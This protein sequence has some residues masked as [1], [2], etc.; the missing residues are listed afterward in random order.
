MAKTIFGFLGDSS[1]FKQLYYVCVEDF[2]EFDLGF[3]RQES[4]WLCIVRCTS[5]SILEPPLRLLNTI[6]NHSHCRNKYKFHIEAF[7]IE[8]LFHLI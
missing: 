6:F 2:L 1:Y 5:E 8:F 7:Y 3:L 4:E